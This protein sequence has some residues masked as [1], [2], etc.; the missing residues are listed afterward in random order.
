MLKNSQLKSILN[1]S[2]FHP[3]QRA[4]KRN[5]RD[6]HLLSW[7][8]PFLNRTLW[9]MWT[10]K[11]TSKKSLLL[12]LWSVTVSP[13]FPKEGM[14]PAYTSAMLFKAM[15]LWH[16][17]NISSWKALMKRKR[18]R[19]MWLLTIARWPSQRMQWWLMMR[20]KRSI[21]IMMLKLWY[22]KRLRSSCQVTT[23]IMMTIVFKGCR[24]SPMLNLLKPARLLSSKKGSRNLLRREVWTIVL[25][26][27]RTSTKPHIKGQISNPNSK[28][29]GWNQLPIRSS[30][31]WMWIREAIRYSM[32]YHPLKSRS[33]SNLSWSL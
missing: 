30:S 13:S 19:W 33:I 5:R 24:I 17:I 6:H 22:W 16:S 9:A 32:S 15:K 20:M 28:V 8:E 29:I 23:V 12:M 31:L 4:C 14:M 1:S 25:A 3:L 2:W 7:T 27:W 11:K 18:S 10:L 21:T 26:P